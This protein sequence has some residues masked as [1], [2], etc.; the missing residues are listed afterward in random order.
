MN[1]LV[2][3]ILNTSGL[4]VA[5]ATSVNAF[6]TFPGAVCYVFVATRIITIVF[7][8][9]KQPF[10]LTFWQDLNLRFIKSLINFPS[11]MKGS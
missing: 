2:S 8:L 4:A 3:R 1:S 7:S 9:T 5:I 10:F 11:N 6:I